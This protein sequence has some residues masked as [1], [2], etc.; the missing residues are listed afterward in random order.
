MKKMNAMN[1]AKN[2]GTP[3]FSGNIGNKPPEA[4]QHKALDDSNLFPNGFGCIGNTWEQTEIQ[5]ENGMISPIPD[6]APEF[7]ARFSSVTGKD[8]FVYQRTKVWTYTN[9][10]GAPVFHVARF[11]PIEKTGRKEF[12][13]LTLWNEAGKAKW[14]MKGPDGLRPM[15]GLGKLAAIPSVDVIVCEGEKSADAAALLFPDL[16]AVSSMGGSKAPQKTDWA[17]L[18]GRGV[19]LWPDADE[20]GEA[21]I[22]AV[23]TLTT[24]AGAVVKAAIRNEWFIQ[25]AGEVGSPCKALEKGFDAA[26][27]LTM[28]FTAENIAAIVTKE[29]DLH[30]NTAIHT[31]TPSRRAAIVATIAANES[32]SEAKDAEAEQKRSMAADLFKDSDFAVVEY[33]KGLKNGVYWQEPYGEDDTPKNPLWLCSPLVVAAETRDNDQGNWGRLLT[34]ED[35]DDH[36]HLWACPTE[37]LAASDTGE[38]RRELMRN[39]VQIATNGKARQKL[40]DYVLTH[41]PLSSD[42][43][44]CVTK[45]GWHQGRYVLSNRVFGKTEGEGVIYQGASSGDYQT[46]GTLADWQREIAARAVGNSRIL[47]A[48]SCSFAGPLSE[49]A[50]ESGG[51]FQFTGETSKGKTSTLMDPAAS[52]WGSPDRF[53]KKWRTTTNG[54]EALCLSRNDSILILDD[55][56]QSDAKE[57]GAS[58]YLIANGQGKARMQKEGGNRPLT[59]WKT[60][61]LSSG[62]LDLAQH[63]A[64][65]GKT[66]RGGQVARLPSIP[67]DAGKGLFALEEL[68][69][70]PD[71]R[72][73]A[74]T[75]KAATRQYF[76]A[77]GVAFMEKLTAPEMLA[78]VK[79]GIRES[80]NQFVEL[81]RIPDGAAGEVGRV[82][83]RFGLVAYAGE[84]ATEFGVTGWPKGDAFKA[85]QRCFNDWLKES[86]GAMGADE[87][88]LFAQ[89]SS[90]LQAHG[91]SRFPPHD[92]DAEGLRRVQNRAGFSFNNGDAVVYWAES[93]AFK[94]ELCKG[95]NPASAAK[96]LH[97]AGWLEAGTDRTQQ[98]KRITALPTKGGIWVY[99]MTDK[100][101]GGEL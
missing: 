22:T 47:F 32:A 77:A 15:Y 11:D 38:F 64:E 33:V 86:G 68:H 20:P 57:C 55:L 100:A 93:G 7:P 83:A 92:I 75:M 37:L 40:V 26:D 96:S 27:A 56:G 19:I 21:F 48:I 24:N 17:P 91:A 98:K 70:Q 88:A 43:L 54:I 71:G 16:V 2:T 44:R 51:G 95:F 18:A 9:E 35:K 89:V 41:A 79:D 87:K 97:K 63:M 81:M 30:G 59:T 5:P 53:A 69:D 3:F 65:A 46:A 84:L 45:T 78:D 39:G 99:V 50:N 13:Q 6:D 80:I 12:R 34:W 8:G 4:L 76:G 62:E 49:M 25:M 66:A 94:K 73:F 23:E 14:K 10:P 29:T 60:L 74:D 58:A 36:P 1:E 28:G 85:A 31:H 42:R 90:F 82:A 52:V 61:L 67:A 101:M 72:H